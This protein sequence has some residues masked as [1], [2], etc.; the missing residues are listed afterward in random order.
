MAMQPKYSFELKMFFREFSQQPPGTGNEI[1]QGGLNKQL[2]P[3]GLSCRSMIHW[4]SK[5]TK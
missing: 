5:L 1:T 4:S 2:N 3:L